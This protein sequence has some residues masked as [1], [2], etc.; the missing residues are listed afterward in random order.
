MSDP[1]SPFAR[2][3]NTL[4]WG[5]WAVALAGL[6]LKAI[7][8]FDPFPYW[9]TDPTRVVIPVSG[10]TPAGSIL[11]D[12]A[13]LLACGAALLGEVVAGRSIRRFGVLLW[14]FG[15]CAVGWH[16]LIRERSLDNALQGISWAAALAAGL[17]ATHICRDDRF[18]R[19]TLAAAF[20][21]VAMFACK[22]V[23][24]IAVE[25][26]AT[27]ASFKENKTAF[28]EAQGWTPGSAQA[29]AFERRLTQAEASGWFGM[30]NVY[31][32]FMAA[33]LVAL[34]G[35]AVIA[36]ERARE[37]SEHALPS[38]LAGL[39]SI[40]TVSGAAGVWMA[41]SKG[42]VAAALLGM[43]LL[44]LGV[45]GQ[46]LHSERWKRTILRHGGAIGPAIVACV[47]IAVLTRGLIGERLGD[48]SLLFRW[49]YMIGASR[50]FASHPMTGIGPAGF[51]D[52]YM[53]AKPPISPEDVA[54][55]HSVLFD[56]VAMLGIGGIAWAALWL[57][58][59]RDAGVRYAR[60]L[61]SAPPP[62]ADP[63]PLRPDA[64][65]VALTILIPSLVAAWIERTLMSPDAAVARLCGI[66]AW[67]ALAISI[68]ALTRTASRWLWIAAA[69]ALA[70]SAHGQIEMTATWPGAAGI[71]M[72]FIGA[73]AA[74]ETRVA[75]QPRSRPAALVARSLAL[76]PSLAGL[77]VIVLIAG[78]VL[79]W[80]TSLR[81]AADAVQPA[82]LIISRISELATRPLPNP[83]EASALA[84]EL[85]SV[86]H[87]APPTTASELEAAANRLLIK[88]GANAIP[89][90]EAAAQVFPSHL[91]TTE[92]LV[93][94]LLARAQSARPAGVPPDSESVNRA[95]SLALNFANRYP[96]AAAWGV[97]GNCYSGADEIL[98]APNSLQGAESAWIEAAKLDPYG[99]GF[100][101][102]LVD[103]LVA[104]H[105]PEE[106]RAWAAEALRRDE[107]QHLDELR[108]LNPTERRRIQAALQAPP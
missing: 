33:G 88:C 28:L 105:K 50:I 107:L 8:T 15:V 100:V 45:A 21:V 79:R 9:S 17:A 73:V 71:F 49:F 104:L 61:V 66:A 10:L 11:V 82:A 34:L 62:D 7:V 39:I 5:G 37:Q 77:G 32:S 67:I 36:W 2:I 40:G 56:Y 101:I 18:R 70:L 30:A 106:A 102:K 22:G 78:N 84:A 94:L 52:A 85:A 96:G 24:Q 103:A 46:R 44:A 25:H 57:W 55:P 89:H 26:P 4:R 16:A 29:L 54:S 48:R 20:G 59:V 47:L 38:G 27:L 63:G 81:R 64:W 99:P 31:A 51:K 80:E 76:L 69:G 23:L 35:W 98:H 108:R 13:I 43:S 91:P 83:A 12:A 95:I 68:L 1:H 14:F 86:L 60:G 90:L 97:V 19:L 42:G 75:T 3:A 74:D 72:L 41:G 6:F 87:I 93:R 65:P 92:A 53:L 58:W